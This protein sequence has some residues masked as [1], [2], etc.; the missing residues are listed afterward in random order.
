MTKASKEQEG[1]HPG[2]SQG[3]ILCQR[4]TGHLV[5]ISVKTDLQKLKEVKQTRVDLSA[6]TLQSLTSFA[7]AA[8]EHYKH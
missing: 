3:K 1:V 4:Y 6:A 7:P 5:G 8:G 2:P